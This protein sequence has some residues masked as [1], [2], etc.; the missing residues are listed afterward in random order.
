MFKSNLLLSGK[1]RMIVVSFNRVKHSV[2]LHRQK[3]QSLIS[4]I[5]NT[6]VCWHPC[7]QLYIEMAS[8]KKAYF[9]WQLIVVP[10]Q[11]GWQGSFLH[12]VKSIAEHMHM[13]QE[14]RRVGRHST[15]NF[16]TRVHMSTILTFYSIWKK[17]STF[18]P[19]LHNKSYFTWPGTADHFPPK[20]IW[21]STWTWKSNKC[22]LS[23][24][25]P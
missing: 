8:V 13:T 20:S 15:W 17:G 4:V 21:N 1:N 24:K 12:V 22:T 25:C 16:D 2:Y 23:N 18:V 10:K 19:K 5:G 3:K 6:C 14:E 11:L 7:L 9:H